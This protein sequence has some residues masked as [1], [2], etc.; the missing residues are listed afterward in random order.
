MVQFGNNR[1]ASTL[2]SIATIGTA[3]ALYFLP[4]W[5]ARIALALVITASA[6]WPVRAVLRNDGD[7]R[8][9]LWRSIGA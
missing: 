4:W 6:Y 1:N 2:M 3:A 7:L 5:W 8:R 9:K